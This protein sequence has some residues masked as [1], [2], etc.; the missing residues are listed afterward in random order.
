MGTLTGVFDLREGLEAVDRVGVCGLVLLLIARPGP[1]GAMA[2]ASSKS[3]K[4][5]SIAARYRISNETYIQTEI[6]EKNEVSD[7]IMGSSAH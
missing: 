7:S 4:H 6:N 2:T 3:S 5:S 1:G